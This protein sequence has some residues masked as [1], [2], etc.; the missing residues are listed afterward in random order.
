MAAREDGRDPAQLQALM[1]RQLPLIERRLAETLDKFQRP[2]AGGETWMPARAWWDGL[3]RQY[4]GEGVEFEPA[5]PPTLARVP[6]SLFDSV[7][8]NLIRNALAKRAADPEV[9][10]RAS[11][12][13][14]QRV[15][16]R[17]Y[18][19]GRAVPGDLQETLLRAPVRSGGQGMGIG[20][21][22]AARQAESAGFSLAL[23]TNRD[24]VVCFRLSG[25]AG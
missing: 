3:G 19:S 5:S 15:E 21:Y 4:R 6:R 22:Q 9:R 14:G 1:R 23:E 18:D 25:P 2:Q 20:L 24:G 16:L 13:C 10:V 17:V 12:D 7:A 11:L 8:D